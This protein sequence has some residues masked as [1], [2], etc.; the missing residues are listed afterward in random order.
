MGILIVDTIPLFRP[1]KIVETS[2]GSLTLLPSVKARSGLMAMSRSGLEL[3]INAFLKCFK[4]S[5]WDARAGTLGNCCKVYSTGLEDTR[6]YFWHNIRE[7]LLS[8]HFDGQVGIDLYIP[9]YQNQ[10]VSNKKKVA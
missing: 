8:S 4:V 7:F 2:H 6:Y 10:L 3:V 1:F 9:K 5:P